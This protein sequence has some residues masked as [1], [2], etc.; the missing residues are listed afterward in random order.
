MNLYMIWALGHFYL[1]TDVHFQEI[2]LKDFFD[3]FP[4]IFL[5]SFS[6]TLVINLDILNRPS[7]FLIFF[8]YLFVGSPPPTFWEM[9]PAFL[10]LGFVCFLKSG[11]FSSAVVFP[12]TNKQKT[13]DKP[14]ISFFYLFED[15]NNGLLIMSSPC[16]PSVFSKLFSVSQMLLHFM[17][18]SSNV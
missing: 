8:Y 11:L 3:L 7:N 10:S 15:I 13:I 14:N 5:C 6:L 2:F 12:K 17:L 9:L 4:S 1:E 16:T 18:L